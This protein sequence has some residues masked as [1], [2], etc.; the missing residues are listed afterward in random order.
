[1]NNRR[2]HSIRP[3]C[4]VSRQRTSP[5]VETGMGVAAERR[6]PNSRFGHL[7]R[8]RRA[9]RKTHL[10]RMPSGTAVPT[11]RARRGE[12]EGIW[13]GL[14]PVERHRYRVRGH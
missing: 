10:L 6:M 7:L 12:E 2:S 3:T 11:S 4:E 1:M 13:G 9:T 5:V 14:T 8:R